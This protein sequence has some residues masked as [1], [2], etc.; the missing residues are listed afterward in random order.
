MKIALVSLL[1]NEFR[2]P[3]IGLMRIAGYLKKNKKDVEI[4]IVDNTFDDIY[5]EIDKFKPDVIGLSTYTSYYQ[6]AIDFSRII[7]SKHPNIKIIV[8]GPHITTLPQSLDKNFDYGIL[9]QG[10]KRTLLL[11]D[12][13]SKNKSIDKIDGLVYHKNNKIIINSRKEETEEDLDELHVIDYTLLNKKYW[14]KKFIPELCDFK[15]STG[16]LTS[17]GCPFDCIFCACKACWGGIR[18]RKI[19]SIVNEIKDLYYN[20]NVRHIDFSDDLFAINKER[21]RKLHDKLKKEKLL[22]RL[23]FTCLAR[24]DIFDGE[25]CQILTDLN[26]KAATFGFESG[27]DRILKY[28]KNSN[29]VSVEK[30]KKAILLCRKHNL[31]AL[32]SLMMAIPAEKISDMKKTIEFIDFARRNGALKV[33]AQVLVPLP[34]TKIWDI[35]KA[36]G[37]VNDEKTDWRKIHIHNKMNPMLLD[38]NISKKEFLE[39]YETAKAKGRFFIYRMFLKT[40]CKNPLNLFY[41]VK[42]GGYYLKRFFSFV[43][44]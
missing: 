38:K 32:G 2:Y 8:G 26:V 42:E 12:A 28:I 16:L 25:L 5:A 35:A 34:A 44:Q 22:G 21:L 18:Y 10:E 20:F 24:A 6:D 27:S 33:W 23:V 15:V 30:N 4:K 36:R 3:L 39:C 13:I 14:E 40:I 43:K 11:L 7:K 37:K 29:N 1:K 19:D 31:N 41:F 17:I 9:G